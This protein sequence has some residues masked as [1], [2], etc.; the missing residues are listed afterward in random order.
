MVGLVAD[1]PDMGAVRCADEVGAAAG[2]VG[3]ELA[4][5]QRACRIVARVQPDDHAE[6]T[7]GE[8]AIVGAA[9]VGRVEPDGFSDQH[10]ARHTKIEH[11]LLTAGVMKAVDVERITQGTRHK[12]SDL[13]SGSGKGAPPR[14]HP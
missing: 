2:K 1:D 5:R 7:V 4:G 6:V 3:V 8:A 13:Q 14:G 10:P 11:M 12:D 9:L